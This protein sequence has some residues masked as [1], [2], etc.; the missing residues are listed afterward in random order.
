MRASPEDDP[1]SVEIRFFGA[2]RQVTGSR[3][4]VSVGDES[5]MI[6]CGLFQERALLDRNWNPSPAPVGTV[7]ALLL[8]HAHIDHTGWVPRFVKLGY[9]GPIHATAPTVALCDIMLR[10]SA[11]IQMEDAAYKRRRHRKEGRRGPHPEVP[12]YTDQDAAEALKL[13]RPVEY[14]T[15]VPIT[16]RITAEWWDAGHIL[17][18]AMIHLR[19]RCAD[20][21]RTIIFSGDIGRHDRP[22]LEDPSYFARADAVVMES[23]YGDRNHEPAGD[24]LQQLEDH[25]RRTF[26]RGGKVIIPVFAVER[27]QELLYY[28]SRLVRRHRLPTIP[29]FLDSPMAIDVT[30]VF[31][32]FRNWMDDETRTLFA[33]GESPLR[34]PGLKMTRTTEESIAINSVKTPCV[35]MAT[36]GMCNAG[37]IK[38]HLKHNIGRPENLILF[39][40][41]QA[42]GTLGRE[43]V[44]G[45]KTVRIHGRF[46][47]VAAEIA[48]MHGF[49]GHADRDGLLRWITHFRPTPR[50]LFLTHGEEG[51]MTSLRQ[52]ILERTGI[53]AAMPEYGARFVLTD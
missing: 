44:D 8:T 18:S 30:D 5:V 24:V 49:S 48:Q 36:A 46:Y 17:G 41:Y 32:R 13:F 35:I 25:F 47:D 3:Y 39:V 23:T 1:M 19:C 6:D 14:R 21:D 27:A 22:L 34:F 10:D 42:Q 11:R 51:P 38:H 45:K 15:P 29:I 37:R 12:L 7:R 31:R 53:R 16:P 43:I 2:A 40:G 20:R 52:A 33:D 28:I 26:A 50:H 4:L 9:S